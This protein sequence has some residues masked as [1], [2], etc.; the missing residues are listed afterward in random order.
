MNLQQI[1][2]CDH[3][4][5]AAPFVEPFFARPFKAASGA[6]LPS[7]VLSRWRAATKSAARGP[8]TKAVSGCRPCFSLEV[9]RFASGKMRFRPSEPKL[10]VERRFS[11]MA[12]FQ[13]RSG[14]SV[15]AGSWAWV[16]FGPGDRSRCVF[17]RLDLV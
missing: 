8:V 3:N 9:L 2:T 5:A 6:N 16:Q 1:I 12:I 7:P 10:R 14:L 11:R 15:E 13:H 4:N 17:I